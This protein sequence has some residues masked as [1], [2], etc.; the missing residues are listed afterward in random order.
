MGVYL[1]PFSLQYSVEAM[2]SIREFE[3]KKVWSNLFSLQTFYPPNS[4]ELTQSM[5]P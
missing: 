5:K 1:S 4:S 2:S 3:R